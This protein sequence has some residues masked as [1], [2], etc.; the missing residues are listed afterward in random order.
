MVKSKKKSNLK[1]KGKSTKTTEKKATRKEIKQPP[2]VK[3]SEFLKNFQGLIDQRQFAEAQNYLDSAA[4]LEKWQRLN[5]QSLVEHRLNRRGKAIEC[6]LQA[7]REPDCQNTVNKNL[8]ML[9][10]SEGQLREALPYAEKAYK[11]IKNDL[12]LT[13]VYLNCLLDLSKTDQVLGITE[14][15]LKIFPDDRAI[16]V[17]RASALR[18]VGR[19][20]ESKELLEKLI[21]MFPGEPVVY[22]IKADLL[23]DEN[24]LEALPLYEK[25]LEV[26]VE[27]TKRP[28][29]A[30]QWNMSLHLLRVRDIERGW[31]FWEQGF[32]PVV[33]TMGRNLPDRIK[34]MDRADKGKPID[35]NKWTIVVSE[36]G[37]GDQILFLSVMNEAIEEFGKILLI[38]EARMHA[39]LKRSFPNLLVAGPGMTYTWA[40]SPVNKNGYVPLGSLPGRYRKTVECFE[41][42]RAPFLIANKE[43]FEKYRK[44]LRERA[45]GKP[46][47]GI[48]WRGGYWAIQRKTKALELEH[49]EPIFKKNAL[50]VNLQYG[51][52]RPELKYLVEKKHQLTVF[53]GIDF[54][55][56]LDDWLSIAGA[57]D[58]IISISTALVHFAGAIGQKVA[59]VMPAQYGPWH[60]GISDHRSIA[61]KNVRIFRPTQKEPLTSLIQRVA[62][63]II[64]K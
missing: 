4:S 11:L 57:C 14:D 33:G 19:K 15:A 7:L 22:R 27:K 60:L 24:P 1:T 51:D 62:D 44:I 21:E 13:Q 5:L 16:L 20:E 64:T 49:W 36:Q 29:P 54:Q 28:D 32:H 10:A 50:F 61:Y 9:Y 63:L 56:D 55:S 17:S 53:K 42:G 34:T 47:I 2:R 12:R 23:G 38:A 52:I 40:N 25:A 46:I 6:L 48:S 18:S 43:K 31:A 45:N 58:G 30:V 3:S 26:S 41:K 59:I 39:I 8:A 37:I 35:K